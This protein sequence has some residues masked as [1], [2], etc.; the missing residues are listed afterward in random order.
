MLQQIKNIASLIR[1]KIE[2]YGQDPVVGIVLGSGLGDLV[3]RIEVLSRV[4]YA[5]IEGFPCSTVIGH[6]GEFIY[7]RLGGVVVLAMNG[8]VHHYEGYTMQQVVLPIRVMCQ[9]GI[10]HLVV[11]NAAGGLNPEFQVGNIMIIDDHINLIPNPLIGP[12][13]QELGTR[14]PAMTHAYDP[15]WREKATQ[16]AHKQGLDIQHGVYAACTGPS[17]ETPAESQYLR[18]I[19]ADAVGM[20]TAPEV[21]VARHQ[22][23]SVFGLSLISNMT[24][25]PNAGTASHQEVFTAAQNA[26]TAIS[27]LVETLIKE[28]VGR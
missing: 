12:N 4:P 5:S 8:R 24:L 25:G 10:K 18:T 19:G 3:N 27:N 1:S 23:V 13:Y 15:L 16:I 22:G 14:F 2:P 20:S 17:Y 28:M 7:G 6:A 21:I 26:T 11:S 9:L